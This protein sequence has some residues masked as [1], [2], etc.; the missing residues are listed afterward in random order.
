VVRI[1]VVCGSTKVIG[2]AEGIETYSGI[3]STGEALDCCLSSWEVLRRAGRFYHYTVDKAPWE[4][5]MWA[6]ERRG[7]KV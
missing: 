4:T 2:K 5:Q 3:L 7:I 6:E 1:C